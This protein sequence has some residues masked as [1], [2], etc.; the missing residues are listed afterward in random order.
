MRL[1]AG[2][3]ALFLAAT[4]AAAAP[5][6]LTEAAV[7]AFVARQE[8]AWNGRD[9]K[10]F[11]AMFAPDA[12]FVDQALGSDNRIVPY[13]AST[14]AEAIAQARKVFAAS[15]VHEVSTIDRIEIAADGD[16][17]RILG[18]E[19]TRIETAGKPARTACAET[20]QIVVL[21]AGRILSRGQ[22]DTA[23]RCPRT[24]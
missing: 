24:R 5:A 23:V 3:A 8:A 7:R 1:G 14:R 2:L 6:R 18:H 12:R 19:V 17:A 20:E 13:G 11:E 4:T 15:R 16:Q 22:T 21:A 9:L 10:A